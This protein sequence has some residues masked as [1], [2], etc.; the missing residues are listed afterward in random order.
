MSLR[1]RNHDAVPPLHEVPDAL[2]PELAERRIV[3]IV[4]IVTLAFMLFMVVLARRRKG[5]R[6]AAPGAADA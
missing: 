1:P 2:G 5:D 6:Y 3:L 4:L